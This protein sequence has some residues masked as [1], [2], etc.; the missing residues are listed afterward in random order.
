MQNNLF[1]LQGQPLNQLKS[2]TKTLEDDLQDVSTMW[3]LGKY[4]NALRCSIF[5]NARKCSN[6]YKKKSFLQIDLNSVEAHEGPS[7]L[8]NEIRPKNALLLVVPDMM[9][10]KKVKCLIDTGSTSNI[11]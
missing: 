7:P 8:A 4:H 11:I 10:R 5:Y 2:S 6:A 1:L 3:N 9:R